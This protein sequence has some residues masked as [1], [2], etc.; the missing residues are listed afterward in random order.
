MS[1]PN[2]TPRV[3]TQSGA[4]M[5]RPSQPL[6][7]QGRLYARRVPLME[8]YDRGGAYWGERLPGHSLYAVQDVQGHTAFFDATSSMNAKAAARA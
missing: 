1:R 2:P 5:G 4:P 8:G 3:N 6:D 7:T